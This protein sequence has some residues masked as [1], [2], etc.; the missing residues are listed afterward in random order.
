MI[1]GN[2][3][4][5]VTP[6]KSG[7]H[8]EL[9]EL[10]AGQRGIWFAQQL[11]PDSPI[12]NIGEY[13]AFRG[14]LNIELFVAALRF[15]IDETEILRL[16]FRV[17]ADTPWQYVEAPGV[18][19]IEVLDVSAE[20][21][22]GAA[23][24]VWMQANFQRPMDLTGGPL[25]NHAVLKVGADLVYWQT[26]LHHIISDGLSVAMVAR[27]VAAIYTA[28]LEG[29]PP[30]AASFPPLA[31]LIDGDSEYQAS[32]V[33]AADKRYWQDVL[34]D[35][36]EIVGLS[37]RHAERMSSGFTRHSESVD[38]D[39]ANRWRAAAERLNTSV[40]RL[41]VTAAAVYL[42]RATG[43]RDVVIGTPILGR[44]GARERAIPGMRSN[45]VPIR[46]RIGPEMAI[47]DQV[48]QVS[49]AG[50]DAF[51]HQRYRYEDI[52][53]DQKLVDGRSLSSLV[54]NVMPFDYTQGFGDCVTTAHNLSNGPVDDVTIAVYDRSGVGDIQLTFDLNSAL[55]DP[56]AGPGIARAFRNVVDWLAAASPIDPLG[57]AELL[58]DGQRAR[59]LSE[60]NDTAVSVAGSTAPELF[61][62]RVAAAAE[63][64]ALRYQDVDLTYRE[65]DER[66]NRL[67][68]Y[69]RGL[70]V[71]PESVVGL[72]LPR[73]VDMVT[74][75]LAVWKAGGAYLPLDPGY[76]VER[77]AFMLSD[78]RAG[79]L[80]ATEDVVADP[81]AGRIRTV[82]L[83]DPLV[84]AA[85]ETSQAEAVDL[86][87]LQVS[88]PAYVIY[89]SGSTGVPKGVVVSHAGVASLV[90]AQ[91][92]T[93]GVGAGSRV[94]QFA[95]ISYDAAV[96]ELLMGLCTGA[97]LILA[98][99][100]DVLPGPGLAGVVARHGV[101]HLTVPPAALA[102][103]GID[104]LA[105]VSTLVVA[106][107]AVSADIVD[108]W[109]GGR[110]RIP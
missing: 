86:T 43:A 54:V 22:P 21:D 15:S 50:R 57:R 85:L 42:H 56:G 81:P 7:S 25:F 9:R 98:D 65:L 67:A 69:L 52:L 40:A 94:L 77:Q 3:G 105:T 91:A 10:M 33:C 23:A 79:M 73:G 109:A 6:R 75:A 108:R 97:T 106:G 17:I 100:A 93:L 13:L 110:T 63:A 53:R 92:Q 59:I 64:S 68:H 41:M 103:L 71:G 48:R 99:A 2:V 20:A 47:E 51:R 82:T 37:G 5:S 8:G 27:R 90:A 83:D 107:E 39:N 34:A 4:M 102:V 46:L 16:R 70:G 88:H 36:P 89:T 96:W 49:S 78:S 26:C 58:D 24:L 84:R 19:P 60:W 62:T 95:S 28:L 30:E 29:R 18:Y 44:T 74:A 1:R 12:Y 31:L 87:A 32:E 35:L 66:S 55:H 80:L 72:C 76:P 11:A 14:T 38:A 61:A 104:A 101:S 45:L